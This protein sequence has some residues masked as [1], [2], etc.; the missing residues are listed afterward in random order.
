MFELFKVACQAVASRRGPIRPPPHALLRS[1][2]LR[3]DSLRS[4]LRCERR[5]V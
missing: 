5:L 3:R 4:P 1:A 2:W